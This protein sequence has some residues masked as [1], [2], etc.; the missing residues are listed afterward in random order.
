VRELLHSGPKR[1]IP[2]IL[3][4][5][6]GAAMDH[7][8][9]EA[10]AGALAERE[11]HLVRFEF[12]YM[13]ARREGRRPPPDRPSVTA[14]TWQ[15]VIAELGGGQSVFIGGKSFGG[16][17]ASLVADAEHVRGLV[18]L[19][20]PFHPTGKPQQLRTEH[21][22]SLQT[23]TLILQGERDAFG[24][25]EEVEAYALSEAIE[26]CWF[27]NSDHSLQPRKA[28]GRTLADNLGIACDAIAEFMRVHD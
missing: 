2:L 25:R 4:H 17:M 8:W 28:S 26:V 23:R 10:L 12:P 21:L 27:A 16:R 22:A 14:A 5:G 20:Y 11:V 3:A 6:A 15:K 1:G 18:C 13:A 19:G 7:P 9:M 24:S